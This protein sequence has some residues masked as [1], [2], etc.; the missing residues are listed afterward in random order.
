MATR[1]TNSASTLVDHKNACAMHMSA[2]QKFA[3]RAGTQMDA[4]ISQ[5]A[6]YHWNMAQAHKRLIKD[7]E[8]QTFSSEIG[9]A[10]ARLSPVDRIMKT[11][12]HNAPSRLKGYQYSQRGKDPAVGRIRA[13]A[14]KATEKAQSSRP[15]M[16]VHAARLHHLAA[17]RCLAAGMSATAKQHLELA[18]AH[19]RHAPVRFVRLGRGFDGPRPPQ[20]AA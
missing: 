15:E 20:P 2:M 18:D 11:Q 8:D 19:G 14:W 1:K 9:S 10:W 6:S 16:H 13:L 7:I 4:E 3:R 5:L 12:T 17:K